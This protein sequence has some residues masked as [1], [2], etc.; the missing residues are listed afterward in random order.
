MSQEV[1]VGTLELSRAIAAASN[2]EVRAMLDRFSDL[3][4][5]VLKQ[6]ETGLIMQTVS[7][8]FNTDFHLGEI[9]VTTA[10]VVLGG[11]RGWGMIMG[12]S[13]DR[14]V[15]A[16]CLDVV[17]SRGESLVEEDITREAMKWLKRSNE[18]IVEEA[19]IYGTTRVSFESM[20]E[21]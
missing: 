10:E 18:F 19:K 5:Q 9:L 21:E 2:D 20:A 15:V 6:P 4:F 11:V 1:V 14:A 13:G 12:D 16:A 8:C 7:D 17:V 3:R